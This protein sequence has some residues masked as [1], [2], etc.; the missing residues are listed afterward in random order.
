MNNNK[1]ESKPKTW[2]LLQDIKNM[3]L[4]IDAHKQIER[5][6]KSR[7]DRFKTI[8]NHAPIAYFIID[9]NGNFVDGNITSFELTG[10]KQEDLFGKT[11]VKV[12]LI[13]KKDQKAISKILIRSA[14]GELTGPDEFTM[15]KKDG[16]RLTVAI[17]TSPITINN[18]KLILCVA[19]NITARKKAQTKLQESEE[20]FRKLFDS[21]HDALITLHPP[22]WNF[23]SGNPAISKMF[24]IKNVEEFLTY[25]PWDISPDKQPDGRSS[26][27]KAKEMIE[28]AMSRGSHYFEWTH[29][30]INGE[31]FPATVLLTRIQLKNETFLQA[32]VRDI[33]DSKQ[34]EEA[35]K[36]SEERLK[37]IFEAAPDAIF[38]CDLKG[39]LLDG[40]KAAEEML[41]YKKEELIGKNLFK[42]NLLSVK[43]LAKA[44]KSL[45]KSV[46]GKKTGPEEFRLTRKDGNTISMEISTYPVNV[47]DKTVILGI[48]RDITERLSA[49]QTGKRAE[50][51]KGSI[52][53]ISEAAHSTENLE[54]LFKLI[55]QA[56]GKLVVAKNFFIALYDADSEMLSFPYFVDEYDEVPAPKKLGRGLTEYVLRT[57]KLLLASP[58]VFEKLVKKGEVES[59]GTPSID[60][61][62]VPLKTKDTTIGVLVIQSYTEGVR[63]K[64]E[65]KEILRYVSSQVAMAIERKQM[66]KALRES[67][68]KYRDLFEK[69]EEAVLII[70][71][72]KFVDCN[73]SAVNMLRYNNK[74]EL[75]NTHP[76]ELSP[77]KQPDGKMSFT[78]ANELMKIALK[79][80]SC[81]FEWDHKKSDGEVFP[82]E[83]LLTAIVTDEKNQILHTVWRDI[84]ERKQAELELR[85]SEEKFKRLFDSLGD[86]VYV[87]KL[88]GKNNGQILEVNRAAVS[89]TGYNKDELLKMNIVKD[90]YI[91]GSG[92]SKGKD[93]KEKLRAGE[94]VKTTEKKRRKDGAEFW[95]EVIISSIEF[96]GK[97]ECLSINHDVTERKQTESALTQSEAEYK[98]IF[99][100]TGTAT[101][102]IGKD[103]TILLAND[104]FV[105]LSG[106]PRE[107]LEGKKLWTEFIVEEDIE[108]MKAQHELQRQDEEQSLQN[109]EFRF[110]DKS[111]KIKDIYLSVNMISGTQYSIA[112][113]LDITE[114]KQTE[115]ALKANEEKYRTLT[116]NLPI[117][118]YRNTSGGKGKFIEVNKALVDMFGF[119][120]REAMLKVNV[121]SLYVSPSTRKKFS[122][123]LNS[124][125]FVRNEELRLLRTDGSTFIGSSSARAIKDE[126][127]KITHYDGYIEDVTERWELRNQLLES[128]EKFRSI[129]DNS[130]D[131]ILRIDL[132]GVITYINYEYASQ[133]PE[134]IIG[135]TLYE[136]MPTEF[137]EIAQSTIKK[138]FTDGLS[139]SFENLSISGDD[140][141][142]W[143]RNN[144]APLTQNGKVIAATIIATD[145][146][147]H[148]HIEIMK[149]E[150]IS[151][152]SHELRT[153]LTIIR[154]SLSILSDGL[155][156]ELNKDQLDLI[157]PCLE[158]VDRLARIINN[159][160]DISRIE[161]QKITLERDIVDIVKLAQSVKS[162]FG[163]RAATKNIKL[164]VT[165]EQESLNLYID[166]DRIIQ[167]FMNLLGNAM[168]F[169]EKGKIEI[170]ITKKV[171]A[172]ECCIAD[173]GR[174]IEEKDIGTLFDRFHQV[175]KIMRAGEKG[176]GL[177]L[178][179]SK[180]IVELHN[181]RIWVESEINNGTKFYF[182]LPQYSADKII[183][184]N[185][186]NAIEDATD[187]HVKLSLLLI[188]LNNYSKIESKFGVD[189]ANKVNRLILQII[190]STLAPGEFSFMKGKDEV[191]LFSDI[192]KQNIIILFSKLGDLLKKSV[193][194]I[195]KELTVELSYGYSL[196][197]DNGDDAK[198]L[199][200][201][202]EASLNKKQDK[203]IG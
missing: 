118:I 148:K 24:N 54:E 22:H 38:L 103:Y 91:F 40:N 41:G 97:I 183:I 172:V 31:A 95:I 43:E 58:E 106:F 120:G 193:S 5:V 13:E 32:T 101:L 198:A 150:F 155:L 65:T 26:A 17:S 137:R 16:S 59:F 23:T 141:I 100:T 86:A 92:D 195:D 51:L 88:G 33:T 74:S 64:E 117:G 151:S 83:V 191:M 11:F 39:N 42:L 196:Y 144:V 21:A 134:D 180:G 135:K 132:Q 6:L 202:A 108:R 119:K 165:S 128:E 89:Q 157:N 201:Y 105:N 60:W 175:G 153:P 121:S 126:N 30:R 173:T 44:A 170:I 200:K 123:K 50:E 168:K 46:Q 67:E 99:Q 116:E 72:G 142:L 138:V 55:H 68:K 111:G 87:T 179:I 27:E 147:D 129:V 62:G 143:Y 52:Y 131:I 49:E 80:G 35:L 185:I 154:E 78:K 18:E 177:G 159:L 69:S 178:S 94:I 186:E 174:G 187:K 71:N 19:H 48:A 190:Q 56:I 110:K 70:H 85:Q 3:E 140:S 114:R 184:N 79:N 161:G 37:V 102:I 93:W 167:V 109:Y 171:N 10:Y 197:P 77:E 152:V 146:S 28:I 145:I 104:G 2:Q 7:E 192:T 176:S 122:D 113:L 29:K 130:P 25:G 63:F 9:L 84:T 166:R 182:T 189:K 61:L 36:D 112:S 81:R 76:S 57:G 45:A 4:E 20:R 75:L 90:L 107:Q 8:F 53:M 156:G 47:Q 1:S 73:Q 98:S 12:N 169:T 15:L 163:N 149:N 127:G 160:L 136:F 158:D 203:A 164:V 188:K 115:G 96:K 14:K 125:G 66:E 181:G 162:S 82:V 199:I 194:K 139:L 34:A 133:K 124:E